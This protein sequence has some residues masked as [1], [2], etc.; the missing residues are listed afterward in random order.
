MQIDY[1][2]EPSANIG[3]KKRK[4]LSQWSDVYSFNTI[5][6]IA[7]DVGIQSIVLEYDEWFICLHL[8]W[9]D[10]FSKP[11]ELICMASIYTS[12]DIEEADKWFSVPARKDVPLLLKDVFQYIKDDYEDSIN[13]LQKSC[14]DINKLCKELLDV[15]I[16]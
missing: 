2:N 10:S 7:Q 5:V 11:G 9:E 14:N 8:E 1:K 12:F 16:T 15:K 13:N 6:E 3:Y 4:D